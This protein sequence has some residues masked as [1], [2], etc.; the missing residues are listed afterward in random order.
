M[1]GWRDQL[2]PASWRGLACHVEAAEAAG[3]RRLA[4]HE[5]PLRDDPYPEDMGR[6]ARTWTVTAFMLGADVLTTAQ[7][8]A[9]ALEETGAGTWIDPWRG[10]IRAVVEQYSWRQSSAEGGIARFEISFREAGAAAYPVLAPDHEAAVDAAASVARSGAIERFGAGFSVTGL[11]AALQQDMAD[12]IGVTMT[13]IEAATRDVVATAEQA[14]SWARAGLSLATDAALLIET[15]ELLAD[16]L[17]ALLGADRLAGM[18]WR[19]WLDIATWAPVL[20]GMP[21][22]G[23][24]AQRGRANRAAWVALVNQAGVI[25][26]ARA[27]VATDFATYDDAVAARGEITAA[28]DAVEA[29]ASPAQYQT[30]VALRTALVRAVSAAAPRLPRVITITRP[31]PLPALTLAWELYG[32]RPGSVPA[33]ADE[34]V[35]RN[36]VPHPLFVAPPVEVL[37]DG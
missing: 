36:R 37:S 21:G 1:T 6:K 25:G 34:I 26:A 19:T 28:M 2:R 8:F 13:D 31:A 9:T 27:A 17:M 22:Q 12:V 32:D 11:A 14:A 35:A 15:P 30:L 10:E 4:L 18:H 7:A 24:A 5:Y 16:R 23:G 20:D 29:A 33:R 3:G